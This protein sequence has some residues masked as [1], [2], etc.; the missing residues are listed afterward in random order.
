MWRSFV[1]RAR[2]KHL[3]HQDPPQSSNPPVS[4]IQEMPGDQQIPSYTQ[5]PGYPQG[6]GYPVTT[7]Y[8]P[9]SPPECGPRP[10]HSPPQV[11]QPLASDQRRAFRR[12]SE[13]NDPMTQGQ[14]HTNMVNATGG[15]PQPPQELGQQVRTMPPEVIPGTEII[16][17]LM[18]V[19]GK[20]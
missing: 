9:Q 10:A 2:K 18:G 15:G 11:S 5:T 3:P 20:I 1:K 19:T 17:A 12:P 7:G 4:G 16:I 14:G 8:R 6:S 13:L